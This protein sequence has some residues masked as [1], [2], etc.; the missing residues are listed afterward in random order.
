MK[1]NEDNLKWVKWAPWKRYEGDEEADGEGPEGVHDEERK[2]E[3]ERVQEPGENKDRVMYIDTRSRVP[4]SFKISR[5]DVYK[6][7]G[8]S[9]CL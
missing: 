8:T 2:A 9:G 5:E 7:T 4:R 3:K 6:H 1:W